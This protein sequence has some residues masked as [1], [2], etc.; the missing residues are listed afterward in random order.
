MVFRI[1]RILKLGLKS[2]WINRLRSALTMLGMVFGVSSV[3]A[4]L[5]IGEGAGSAALERYMA[6]GV[7]NIIIESVKPPESDEAGSDTQFVSSYGLT[8]KDAERLR[9][10][11]PGVEVS[12]PS[13][14]IRD[15]VRYRTRQP[16]AQVV[17]TVPWYR[18]A[19]KVEVYRPGRF[20]T[21]IDMRNFNPVCVISEALVRKLFTYEDP[22]GKRV[23][24]G[25]NVYEVVGVM[26][27]SG[28]SR[29]ATSGKSNAPPV[30]YVPLTTLN[31]YVGDLFVEF[32]QGQRTFEKV[33]L[34]Q[35]ILSVDDVDRVLSTA[36][37][38]RKDLA[39]HH[40]EKDYRLVVPSKLLKE[41]ENTK[42]LFSFL[43]GSTAAISLLVGGIGIMNIMLATV[44][45]RTREI[46][47]RRALG[48]KRRDIVVQFVSESV[49]LSSVGGLVGMSLGL[50][51]PT[52]VRWLGEFLARSGFQGTGAEEGSLMTI[53]QMK[54]VVTPWAVILAFS[55]S[56]LV[57]ILF[58][59]YPAWRAS[60]MDPIEALR[61]E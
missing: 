47:I 18:D 50:L 3:I 38:V 19:Q 61:H 30:M 42:M 32:A 24:V 9:G 60:K 25:Q 56:V 28:S 41:A 59:L 53:T 13:R 35:I 5:A 8:Y 21:E 7:N 17:G 51:T 44:T 23:L 37:V 40:K 6:L 11:L 34:H 49:I 2:L 15:R 57:G 29:D 16:T 46:G 36:A 4:I 22:L 26:A 14:R 54:A 20:L 48:A 31:Q 39:D 10:T 12:V 58:G 55:V 27:D 1:W 33:E 45:E 52:F 43:L